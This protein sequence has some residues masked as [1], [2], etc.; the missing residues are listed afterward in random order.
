MRILVPWKPV[1]LVWGLLSG[2]ILVSFVASSLFAG[3]DPFAPSA[4]KTGVT[5]TAQ[6]PSH[7]HRAAPTP[8]R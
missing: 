2:M 1:V 7:S 8:S 6:Q 5:Q 4:K 3:K